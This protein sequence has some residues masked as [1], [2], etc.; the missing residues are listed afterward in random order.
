[1]LASLQIGTEKTTPSEGMS[2]A[3]SF[4]L[5]SDSIDVLF[6]AG[7]VEPPV[8]SEE[9]KQQQAMTAFATALSQAMINVAG[10]PI[11]QLP[12]HEKSL[13]ETRTIAQHMATDPA[14]ILN[15]DVLGLTPMFTHSMADPSSLEIQVVTAELSGGGEIQ[16][17]ILNSQE[18]LLLTGIVQAHSGSPSNT[19]PDL[20][21]QT[22]QSFD[23]VFSN[24][25]FQ[26]MP[27]Q[28]SAVFSALV[29]VLIEQLGKKIEMQKS[30]FVISFYKKS[31]RPPEFN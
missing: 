26:I 13:A 20:V 7:P 9:E 25:P 4:R 8:L 12:C 5:M 1:M 10:Q 14:A 2:F 29:D 21:A 22:E 6:Q 30:D 24:E 19:L 3:E 31:P 28:I 16:W 27:G 15:Q 17:M 11:T 18:Q 23:L